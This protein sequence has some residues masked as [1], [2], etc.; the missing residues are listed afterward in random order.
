LQMAARLIANA[1]AKPEEPKFR[2]VRC[3]NPKLVAALFSVE[4]GREL[5]LASGFSLQTVDGPDSNEKELVLPESMGGAPLH[6]CLSALEAGA[7]ELSAAVAQADDARR[8]EAAAATAIAAQAQ[9]NETLASVTAERLTREK[10]ASE[11]RMRAEA[12]AATALRRGEEA[13]RKAVAR[14]KKEKR[15]ER[16]VENEAPGAHGAASAAGAEG[17]LDELDAALAELGIQPDGAAGAAQQ[18][19]AHTAN[20]AL[21]GSALPWGR[22]REAERERERLR[23][24]LQGKIAG[25]ESHKKAQPKSGK[26]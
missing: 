24:R 7:K 25:G 26:K 2:R 14:A 16:K 22:D 5:L 6:A 3:S 13:R 1:I 10:E 20:G 9:A 23:A 19:Q 8:C 17:D 15:K 4:G 12:A 11:E 18:G 21:P